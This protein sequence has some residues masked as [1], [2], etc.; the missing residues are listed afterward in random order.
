MAPAYQN[1]SCSNILSHPL[2]Y[3]ALE[4]LE[5]AHVII[6]Q[7]LPA[8]ELTCVDP[9][10]PSTHTPAILLPCLA[11]QVG[12]PHL[13]AQDPQDSTWLV[14]VNCTGLQG[15]T[16]TSVTS[17]TQET[18]V[19]VQVSGLLSVK[20]ASSRKF[21]AGGTQPCLWE[22]SYRDTGPSRPSARLGGATQ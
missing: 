4:D 14:P 10:F 13:P 15:R 9:M 3:G 11:L 20:P 8:Q 1:S 16:M 18:N 17:T 22:G 6:W 7:K 19:H 21:F 12:G 5:M 2:R